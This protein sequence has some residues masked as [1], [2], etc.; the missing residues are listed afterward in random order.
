MATAGAALMPVITEWLSAPSPEAT[1][2]NSAVAD[3]DPER[4]S[5]IST[6]PARHKTAY[7][8]RNGT[9]NNWVTAPVNGSTLGPLVGSDTP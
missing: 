5:T 6:T 8:S 1:G 7:N 4:Q 2:A 9:A 3:L